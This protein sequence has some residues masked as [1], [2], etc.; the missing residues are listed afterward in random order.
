MAQNKNETGL[1]G[2]QVSNSCWYISVPKNEHGFKVAREFIEMLSKL[3]E[4]KE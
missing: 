1:I 2:I 3:L 4:T